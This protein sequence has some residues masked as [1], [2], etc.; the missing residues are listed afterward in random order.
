VR[1]PALSAIPGLHFSVQWLPEMY[2]EHIQELGFASFC[3]RGIV[4]DLRF[5]GLE[6]SN[7]G[8]ACNR[9][10]C[11]W[12]ASR[13][14][15]A[16]AAARAERTQQMV[17]ILCCSS[18]RKKSNRSAM[19]KNVGASGSRK[20]LTDIPEMKPSLKKREYVWKGFHRSM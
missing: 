11:P 14:D 5:R 10:P 3:R 16:K 6:T 7:M 1:F 8:R 12:P 2:Y 4:D 18:K 20:P 15:L 19:V 13:A 9:V 17:Q